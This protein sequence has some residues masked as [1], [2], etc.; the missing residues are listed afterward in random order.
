[1]VHPRLLERGL[2]ASP[3]GSLQRDARAPLGHGAGFRREGGEKA[4]APPRNDLVSGVLRYRCRGILILKQ[5]IT[6][7]DQRGLVN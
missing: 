6:S 7:P 4:A 2:D 1:M 5:Q 3:G